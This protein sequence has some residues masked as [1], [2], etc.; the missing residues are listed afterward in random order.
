MG[1]N[2]VDITKHELAIAD[3]II[4]GS[5]SVRTYRQKNLAEKTLPVLFY[6]HGGG[7]FG[8]SIENI[9]QIC[10]AFAD[11]AEIEVVSIG[12]RLAPENP[13][14]AGLL[15]CYNVVEYYATYAKKELVD[16]AHFTIAGDSAGG[17]L[18]LT[19][20]LLDRAYFKTNYLSKVVLYYPV[21]DLYSTADSAIYDTAE[22]HLEDEAEKQLV[23]GYIKGFASG[24]DAQIN[25]WYG[26]DQD[27]R[28]PLIS[29]AYTSDEALKLLP[30]VK[31][32]IGEFDPLRLQTDAFVERLIKLDHTIEYKIYNGMV[33]AF[34]DKVGD[35]PQA[36]QG[37]DDAIA[38]L[39]N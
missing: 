2:A 15:D 18:S 29:P 6:I 5:V 8:G 17:N 30:P 35:Y 14:P 28:N 37:I 22:Y 3:E 38:F 34:L 10:R 16:K 24:G 27:R 26:G 32:I 33:H 39:K 4:K 19:T 13:F 7:F 31:A 21:V 20:A 9:E 36:E 11:K 1:W 23:H 25:E 12:Y